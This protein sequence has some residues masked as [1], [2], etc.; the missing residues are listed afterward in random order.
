MKTLAVVSSSLSA[1]NNIE[2]YTPECFLGTQ[3]IGIH[4]FLDLAS[5]FPFYILNKVIM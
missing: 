3:S 2:R 4:V 5:M 1:L